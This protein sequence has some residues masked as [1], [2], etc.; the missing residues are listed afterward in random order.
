LIIVCYEWVYGNNGKD[1][2][3]SIVFNRYMI[4]YIAVTFLYLFIRF[5]YFY[6][7]VEERLQ[8]WELTERLLTVPW[9]LL[10]YIKLTFF[11]LSLS[12]DYVIKPVQSLGSLSFI[13][14][15]IA[16]VPL[17]LISITLRKKK[18]LAFG[19]LFFLITLLPVYNLI[20][21]SN[22]FA[23]R[24]LYLPVT[25]FVIIIGMLIMKIPLRP[26]FPKGEMLLLSGKG[27]GEILKYM[28][29]ILILSIF[30]LTLVKRNAVWLNDYLITFRTSFTN[31]IFRTSF[32]FVL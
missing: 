13:W 15:F 18:E 3:R 1:K 6:N 2:I 14:P 10:N 11:P 23:E 16:V 19:I 26:P 12:A 5:Y 24:Y 27:S 25:G 28:L 30:A 31:F 20:P 7:P 8:A 17:L 4:G 32:T 9:L 21:I 22:P 29:V